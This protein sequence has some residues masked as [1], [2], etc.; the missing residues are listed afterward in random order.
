LRPPHSIGAVVETTV[1]RAKRFPGARRGRTK[2]L[3]INHVAVYRRASEMK[4]TPAAQLANVVNASVT[5]FF[6]SV[7]R[8]TAA[9]WVAV[10]RVDGSEPYA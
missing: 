4:T 5:M 7:Q 2:R 10:F 9:P 6:H 8:L 1:T 3:R